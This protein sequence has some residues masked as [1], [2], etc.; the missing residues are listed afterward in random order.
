MISLE[1][2][3]ILLVAEPDSGMEKSTLS[4]KAQGLFKMDHTVALATI[5]KLAALDLL[6]RDKSGYTYLSPKGK[7]AIVDTKESL[8]YLLNELMFR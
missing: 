4:W 1:D 7:E 6:I 3:A 5:D 2:L 8:K